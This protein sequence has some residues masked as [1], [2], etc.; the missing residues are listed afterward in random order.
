MIEQQELKHL[1]FLATSTA[2]RAGSLIMEVYNSDDFQVNLKSDATPLTLA[3]RK[4]HDEILASLMKTRIPVL[5]EEGRNL[6]FEERQGWEYFWLV[7]PL[8][9]TKDFIKRNGEFTVNIA[10][11]F[12]GFPIMGV[13]FVPVLKQLF[14]SLKNFGSYRIDNIDGEIESFSTF[15][16]LLLNAAKLP[17]ASER[18]NI[19]IVS[20]RSHPSKETQ[21]YIDEFVK[22]FGNVQIIPRGS[23]MKICMVA[24]GNADIYP[25]FGTTTEW[26]TAAGQAIAEEAG[27]S[28]L[29]L[30]D[31]KRVKYNKESLENPWFIV[32]R[33]ASN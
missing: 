4:A 24:E 8:D 16:N 15:T 11:I 33:A 6:H 2:L 31:G 23:S 20:S 18:N 27:C 12:E 3:D 21:D 25:R 19:V 32:K 29:S 5:S 17:V 10:L 13:V 1:L 22:K 26:D 28:V 9:G 30:I 14:V 7:D